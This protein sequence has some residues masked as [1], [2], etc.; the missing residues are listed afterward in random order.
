MAAPHDAKQY[1]V[2]AKPKNIPGSG[3]NHTALFAFENNKIFMIHLK[4]IY[5]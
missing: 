4:L 3:L 2:W 1:I 5:V